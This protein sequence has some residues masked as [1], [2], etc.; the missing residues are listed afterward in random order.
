MFGTDT[1][2]RPAAGALDFIDHRQPFRPHKNG[3]KRAR[4]SAGAQSQAA[5]GTHFH[6]PAE[7][8][9][10]AAVIKAIVNIFQIGILCAE[11][12]A[13]PRDIRLLGLNF[14]PHDFC[15]GFGDFDSSGHARI[16]RC[17]S[18]HDRLGIRAATRQPAT[19]SVRTRQFALNRFDLGINID[20]K[21]F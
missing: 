7:Q 8:G 3:I 17:Y 13:W 9:Y 6:T 14:D 11:I 5:D 10:G 2:T 21:D 20:I 19:A 16:G 4:L 15:D 12:A 1:L 18:R